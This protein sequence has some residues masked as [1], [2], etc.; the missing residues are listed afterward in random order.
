MKKIIQLI[1]IIIFTGAVHGISAQNPELLDKGFGSIGNEEPA[2]IEKRWMPD[3]KT[4]Y[5]RPDQVKIRLN[6]R[7]QDWINTHKSVKIGVSP[8]YPPFIFKEKNTWKGTHTDYFRLIGERTGIKFELVSEHPSLWDAKAKAGEIDMFP[9]IKTMKRKL[10][11]NI[12]QPFM[13]YKLVIITRNDT[14]FTSGI[15]T[16]KGK[17]VAMARGGKLADLILGKYPEIKKYE[18]NSITEALKAVSQSKADALVSGMLLTSYLIWK[19]GFNNLKIAGLADLPDEELVFVVRKDFPELT[20]I[21]NKAIASIS[22]EEHDAILQKWYTLNVEFKANWSE[23]LPWII[24]VAGIF[25]SIILLSFL[26][27]RRLA[28]EIFDRKKAENSLKQSEKQFRAMFERHQAVMYLLDPE[29]GKIV[30]AN[31][32]AEKFYG[33]SKDVLEQMLIYQ[34]NQLSREEIAAKLEDVKTGRYKSMILPHRLANGEIRDVEIHSSPIPFKGKNLLFSVVHDITERRQMEKEVR[35]AKDD[36]E[37]AN[38]AKSTFLASMSHELRTPLNGI[39]GYAQILKGD[40]EMNERQLDGIDVIEKSGKHLLSLLSDI[41]DLAKVESNKI[42]L[43]ETDFNL[44]NFIQNISNNIRIRTEKKNLLFINENNDINLYIHAD[45]RRLRQILINLLG[46]SVKFTDKGTITLKVEKQEQDVNFSIIDTGTG[47]SSEDIQKI[48]DPFHQTGDQKYQVQGTGL[49]LSITRNL[50]ELMGGKLEVSSQPGVGSTFSFKLNL[51]EVHCEKECQTSEKQKVK[52]FKGKAVKIL[53]VD[54]NKFNLSVFKDLLTPL[55]FIIIQAENGVE[56]LERVLEFKPEVIITDLVMP[57]MNGIELI[58]QIRKSRDLKDII[59]FAT[60]ASVYSEDQKN[61]INA[62]ADSFFS[63]PIDA[64]YILDQ[65]QQFLNLEWTYD[66]VDENTCDE[67]AEELILPSVEIIETLHDFAQVGAVFEVQ[68]LLEELEQS[69][70]KY[71][72]FVNNL[73]PLFKDF[74]F[75]EMAELMGKYLNRR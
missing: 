37:T 49:G 45:E 23:I 21:L 19:N 25:I 63:K 55:G 58:Q 11:L 74:L 18:V 51:P 14:P 61:S 6:A 73:Q 52:G 56:G 1:F 17:T 54:D 57:K 9:N 48:F 69:D 75:E 71:K 35:K 26:W 10:N 24:A 72:A 67:K 41:L 2:E 22:K 53:M 65:L 30:L 46:N 7:E 12:T 64:D 59:I 5:F 42:E 43:Y 50:I 20:G 4:R 15:S 34:I 36:A 27:N 68:K 13:D 70:K 40:P 39:L 16:L 38:R 66:K 60:S 29:N 31:R 3:P 44:P 47:I 28:K 8:E 33:Y 62:G 32:S